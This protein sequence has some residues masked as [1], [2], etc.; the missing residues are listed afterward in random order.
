[1]LNSVMLD[2]IAARNTGA[3]RGITGLGF[4]GSNPYI[5]FMQRL[6]CLDTVSMQYRI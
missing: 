3:C 5:A 6:Q 1:M 4:V 2:A